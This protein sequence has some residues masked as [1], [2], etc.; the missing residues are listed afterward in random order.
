M[1]NF[2]S[3]AGDTLFGSTDELKPSDIRSKEQQESFD[4]L[5]VSS[6]QKAED[7]F[8]TAGDPFPS[9]LVNPTPLTDFQQGLFNQIPG[10]FDQGD[11]TQNPL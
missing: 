11:F 10:L 5:V 4:K 3:D 9:N 7:F 1:G 2:F 6:G 8:Q